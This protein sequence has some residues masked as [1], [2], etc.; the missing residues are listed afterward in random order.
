M[1]TYTTPLAMLKHTV[2]SMREAAVELQRRDGDIVLSQ[3]EQ[4][5]LGDWLLRRVIEID[6]AVGVAVVSGHLPNLGSVVVEGECREI[7]A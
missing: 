2:N 4:R 6:G 1:H 7:G 3:E 5:A